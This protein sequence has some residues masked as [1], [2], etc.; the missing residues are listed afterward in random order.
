MH[1]HQ[2]PQRLTRHPTQ[3]PT[4]RVSAPEAMAPD[5]NA[6]EC[7]ICFEVI[8]RLVG[9]ESCNHVGVCYACLKKI[10]SRATLK[11]TA[12]CPLCRK[13]FDEIHFL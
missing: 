11:H 1:H 10:R 13:E 7:I 2:P 3:R 9:T 12:V 5:D 8:D 6:L 4:Q